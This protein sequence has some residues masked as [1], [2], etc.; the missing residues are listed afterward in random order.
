M[1]FFQKKTEKQTKNCKNISES[2]IKM[3]GIQV[4]FHGRTET[5]STG[6]FLKDLFQSTVNNVM[7]MKCKRLGPLYKQS[8]VQHKH[9]CVWK[10][11][12]PQTSY[13]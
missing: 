4:F 7:N 6:I 12:T 3:L 11:V 10:K 8:Y 2:P 13:N 5:R 9:D 1:K